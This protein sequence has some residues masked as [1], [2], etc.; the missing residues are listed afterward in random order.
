[1]L[2]VTVMAISVIKNVPINRFVMSLDPAV[3]PDDWSRTDPRRRWR[4]WNLL[5]TGLAAAALG[6]NAGGVLALM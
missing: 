4:N 1:M 2:L 3:R 5:R 6:L